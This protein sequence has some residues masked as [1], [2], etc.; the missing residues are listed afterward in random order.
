MK[1]KRYRIRYSGKRKLILLTE[2][3]YEE[4][5]EEAKKNPMGYQRITGLDDTK[6]LTDDW[7]IIIDY[8]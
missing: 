6:I 3:E 7:T 5:I 8:K 2:E 1:M 4:K